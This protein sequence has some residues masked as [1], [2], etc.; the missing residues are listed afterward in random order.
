MKEVYYEI[1]RHPYTF[2]AT[3]LLDK[4][5]GLHRVKFGGKV[6]CVMFS[7]YDDEDNP[8]LDGLGYGKEC[9]INQIDPRDGLL[10]G[11]GTVAMARAAMAFVNG[12][13]P[14]KGATYLKDQSK[15]TC[16]MKRPLS[17]QHYYIAK[18]LKTWY[19]AKLGAKLVDDNQKQKY[20]QLLALLGSNHNES[21][22][23]FVEKCVKPVVPQKQ[24]ESLVPIL[25]EYYKS[26]KTYHEFLHNLAEDKDCII[27]DKWLYKFMTEATDYKFSDALW[28][29]PPIED[30]ATTY[31][32]IKN[33]PRFSFVIFGGRD[34]GAEPWMG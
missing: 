12:I 34:P 24:R 22:D 18:H 33:K 32:K 25:E 11:V 20:E 19:E 3:V 31:K 26:S 28:A 21:F 15:I 14:G 10:P 30:P 27:F 29:V 5:S 9:A 17:L 8:N 16:A 4:K 7:I 6:G 1:K 13:F 2:H 23:Y